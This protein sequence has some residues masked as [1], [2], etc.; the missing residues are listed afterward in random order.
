MHLIIVNGSVVD[1]LD[2]LPPDRITIIDLLCTRQINQGI[3]KFYNKLF[4]LSKQISINRSG[5]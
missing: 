3:Q 1:L 4:C 2:N 5:L